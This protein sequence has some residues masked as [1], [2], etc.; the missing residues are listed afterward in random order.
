M[1]SLDFSVIADSAI[2]NIS[3]ACGAAPAIIAIVGLLVGVG[4]IIK[5][6]QK[7]SGNDG[8]NEDVRGRGTMKGYND[9]L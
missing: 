1:S 6:L 3:D 9:N 4:V 7:A 8:T 5:L 2:S